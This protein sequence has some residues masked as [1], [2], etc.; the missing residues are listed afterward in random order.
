M[1]QKVEM[2]G[3]QRQKRMAR[4]K[5]KVKDQVAALVQPSKQRFATAIDATEIF[6]VSRWT[7]YRAVREG[8][9]KAVRVG[10]VPLIDLSSAEQVQSAE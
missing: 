4:P 6:G 5:L 8:R 1:A 9:L 2:S 3:K 10:K 7:I